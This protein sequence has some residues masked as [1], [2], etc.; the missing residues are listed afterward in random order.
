MSAFAYHFGFEFRSDPKGADADELPVSLGRYVM[1]A[2]QDR[3]TW[4]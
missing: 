3:S 1:F 2:L 4:F